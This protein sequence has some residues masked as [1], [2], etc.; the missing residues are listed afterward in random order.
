M[1]L[2]STEVLLCIKTL[3]NLVASDFAWMRENVAVPLLM[4]GCGSG[5]IETVVM[6][7][8]HKILFQF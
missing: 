6:F 8:T 4:G 5:C 7:L 3:R 1:A 2:T